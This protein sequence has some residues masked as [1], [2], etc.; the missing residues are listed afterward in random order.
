MRPAP[1]PVVS[2]L[3][4]KFACRWSDPNHDAIGEPGVHDGLQITIWFQL[5]KSWLIT[6]RVV[7]LT[8]VTM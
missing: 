8:G 3:P 5:A 7:S 6:P 2:A 4:V 1:A